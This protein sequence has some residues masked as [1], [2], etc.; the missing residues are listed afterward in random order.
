ML[1]YRDAPPPGGSTVVLARAPEGF[2]AYKT[3]WRT[4]VARGQ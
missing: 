1:R 2:A 4:A 3:R